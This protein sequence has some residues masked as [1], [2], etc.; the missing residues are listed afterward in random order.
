MNIRESFVGVSEAKSR[1]PQVLRGLESGETNHVFVMRNNEPVAVLVPTSA[2]EQM[3]EL[4]ELK[5]H[6]EDALLVVEANAED[7][8]KRHNLDEVIAELGIDA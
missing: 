4:E 7:S 5:E 3:Q 2:Y 6:L 8:G 1:L